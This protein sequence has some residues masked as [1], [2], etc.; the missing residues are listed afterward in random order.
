MI[1]DEVKTYMNGTADMG[2]FL[3][4]KG[5]SRSGFFKDSVQLSSLLNFY[6]SPSTR[7]CEIIGPNGTFKSKLAEISLHMLDENVLIFRYECFEATT[8]DDIFL[9]LFADLR[10]YYQ[11]GRISLAKIETNSLTKKIN[12]YLSHI[13]TPAVFV[14]DSFEKLKTNHENFEEISRFAAH[15]AKIN[16]FKTVIISRDAVDIDIDNLQK[17]ELEPFNLLQLGLYLDASKIKAEQN[18]I[19]RFFTVTGGNTSSISLTVNIISLLNTSLNALLEEFEAKQTSYG[20]FLLQKLIS[21]VPGFSKETLTMFALAKIGFT[22]EYLIGKNFFI[23]EQIDYL[24]ERKILSFGGGYVYMKGYLKNFW[25]SSVSLLEKQECHKFLRDFYE[26]QLPLKPSQRIMPLSRTT[27]REQ[28]AFHSSFLPDKP[29]EKLDTSYLGYISSNLTEWT[30]SDMK[31]ENKS[32]EKHSLRSDERK[33]RSLEKYELT[34][35]E[36]ALLG[37]P[38]NLSSGSTP[39][40]AEPESR[41]INLTPEKSA[42]EY[43]NDGQVLQNAH[44]YQEALD[45]Y[46]SA[47][48]KLIPADSELVRDIYMSASQ[49]AQKL[50]NIDESVKY[51]DSLYDYYYE[52]AQTDK[53]DEILLEIANLY[54]SSYRFLKAKDI[55]ERFLS[56]KLPVTAKVLVFSHIG[57]AQI[58]EESSDSSAAIEHYQKAFSLANSDEYSEILSDAYF[59]YA[60]LLDDAER[61]DEALEYYHKSVQSCDDYRNNAYLSAAFTNIAE[62]YNEKADF[63]KA[64]KY[65]AMALKIDAELSNY[66][67][68]YYLSSKLVHVSKIVKPELVLNFIL[69][70]L[71]ASKRLQ[72]SFYMVNSYLEAGDYYTENH[73]FE[74]AAKAFLNARKILLDGEFQNNDLQRIDNRLDNLKNNLSMTEYNRILEGFGQ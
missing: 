21:L 69:K 67:G 32:S 33:K 55:Y 14:F 53:A 54:K 52:K 2:S 68:I 9:A 16:R 8:L 72:D 3:K 31:K 23:E 66:D 64:F 22:K 46:D 51:L 6:E 58:A 35:E 29:G 62:I 48:Q 27:M 43:F 44:K 20:D 74:K 63:K 37:L 19:Q 7:L 10:T 61:T 25:L 70:S 39:R 60:M 4:E 45:E 5:L 71:S 59:K 36:L 30:M 73:N 11:M 17:I 57:L 65:F 41:T 34:K 18:D 28:S 56:S 40:T 12:Q 49:C 15:I 50:N 1:I 13:T 47:I 24:I 42:Q 26:S 38:V